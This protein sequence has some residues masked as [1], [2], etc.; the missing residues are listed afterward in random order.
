MSARAGG[1]RPWVVQRLSAIYMVL[2]LSLFLLTIFFGDI[3]NYAEW[4]T[5]FTLPV[6]NTAVIIFW[7]ALFSHAWIGIRDVV[8]D[9]ISHDG[10]RFSVLSLLGFYLIAMAVWMIKIMIV[11]VAA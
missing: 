7:I 1:V 3:D 5:W 11:A 9:Y 2:I 8:M 10:V 6:W 4:H